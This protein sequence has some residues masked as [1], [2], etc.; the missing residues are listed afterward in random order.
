MLSLIVAAVVRKGNVLIRS[1]RVGLAGSGRAYLLGVVDTFL[2]SSSAGAVV[3][4]VFAITLL[5]KP[6]TEVSHQQNRKRI[7]PAAYMKKMSKTPVYS[8]AQPT[9]CFLL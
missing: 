4:G 5:H 8:W 7:V 2:R 6:K 9:F 1:T 3:A